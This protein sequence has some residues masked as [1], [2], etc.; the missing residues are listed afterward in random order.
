MYYTRASFYFSQFLPSFFF[1][2]YNMA[3]LTKI[4][5]WCLTR[6]EPA[7]VHIYKNLDRRKKQKI[8]V[9]EKNLASPSELNIYCSKCFASPIE[10]SWFQ[11]PRLAKARSRSSASDSWEAIATSE[12]EDMLS[13][14]SREDILDIRAFGDMDETLKWRE[15]K[16]ISQFDIPNVQN[17]TSIPQKHPS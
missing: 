17:A 6:W 9:N 13:M 10:R 1:L 4:N 16:N 11:C 15:G 7:S 3:I 8:Q 2:N 12:F 14:F 5:S